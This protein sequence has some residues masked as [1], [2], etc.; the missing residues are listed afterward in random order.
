MLLC[1]VIPNAVRND[2]AKVEKGEEKVGGAQRGNLKY[3]PF[4]D[5][6]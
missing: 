1:A 6:K 5:K 4:R 2:G 3:T